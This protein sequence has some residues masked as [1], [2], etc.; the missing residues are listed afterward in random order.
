MEELHR[1][2]I[3]TFVMIAPILPGAEK[4]VNLVPK[5]VD[6]ILID[7]MNYSYA[8]KVYKENKLE[9]AKKEEFFT[10]MKDTLVL[11]LK[12]AGMGLKIEILF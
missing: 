6:Y 3:K 12:K 2:G 1:Y 8:D 10:R 9:Y 7:K 5:V 4:L 11:G